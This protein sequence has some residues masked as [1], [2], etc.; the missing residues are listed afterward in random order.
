MLHLLEGD[1]WD[2][3]ELLALMA[4]V[5]Q[6][7]GGGASGG[8]YAPT[9]Q[10]PPSSPPPSQRSHAHEA[11]R[12]PMPPLHPT[13]PS[14][15]AASVDPMQAAVKNFARQLADSQHTAEVRRSDRMMGERAKGRPTLAIESAMGC[16]EW[17]RPLEFDMVV[18]S[19]L[20]VGTGLEAADVFVFPDRS[21][22]W[23]RRSA[24]ARRR[25]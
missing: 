8:G 4:Q 12:S 22:G 19:S 9:P 1:R 10:R 2:Q 17:R 13:T 16:G 18:K 5:Q 14:A 7:L 21:D 20:N 3:Q 6:Q 25:R 24:R 23:G 11:P 15:A